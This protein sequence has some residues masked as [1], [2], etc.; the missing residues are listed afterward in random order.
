MRGLAAP[1]ALTI[2]WAY[3]IHGWYVRTPMVGNDLRELW[4]PT[5]GY[6]GHSLS[7]GHVP[8]WDPHV[9]SGRPFAADPQSGWLYLMPMALFTALPA[10]TAIR[11]MMVLPPMLAALAL[12]AFCRIEGMPRIAGFCGGAALLGL[13]TPETMLVRTP[14]EGDAAVRDDDPRLRRLAAPRPARR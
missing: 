11:L 5:W 7:N 14:F 10:H 8:L 12:Y 2:I 6:L 1:A 3:L 13:T 4:L 9:L